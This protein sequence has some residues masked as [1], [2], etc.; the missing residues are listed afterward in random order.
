[1]TSFGLDE[2]VNADVARFMQLLPDALAQAGIAVL[3]LD[4]TGHEGTRARGA[5]SKAA[6]V[7]AVYKVSGGAGVKPD[8]HGTLTLKRTRSRSGRLADLVTAGSGG[9]RHSQLEPQDD[10]ESVPDAKVAHRRAE[11][12]KM[13]AEN[14]DTDYDVSALERHAGV[15]KN[16]VVKDMEALV[17]QGAAERTRLDGRS[18]WWK[19]RRDPSVNQPGL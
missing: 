19:F 12:T 15:S 13:L 1:L 5:I 9:G 14:P 11:L 17:A 8:K 10:A 7:E 16:T 6:L 4:N 3:L 18:K 2:N